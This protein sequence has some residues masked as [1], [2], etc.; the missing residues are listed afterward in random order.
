MVVKMNK[1]DKK[2]FFV[3][4]VSTLFVIVLIFCFAVCEKNMVNVM[5]ESNQANLHCSYINYKN[6]KLEINFMGKKFTL[7]LQN[8]I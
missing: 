5:F 8:V 1:S 4:M 3:A 7:S 6:K 2:C